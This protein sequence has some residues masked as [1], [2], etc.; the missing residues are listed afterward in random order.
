MN[1][2]VIQLGPEQHP[3]IQN[4]QIININ[5]NRNNNQKFL[6]I[7][8]FIYFFTIFSQ[9]LI[10]GIIFII[11]KHKN[12]N[13]A[14]LVLYCILNNFLKILFN[15][16][17]YIKFGNKLPDYK[18]VYTLEIILYT[19]YSIAYLGYYLN[20]VNYISNKNIFYFSLPL[21]PMNFFRASYGFYV[22]CKFLPAPTLYCLDSVF[23]LILGFRFGNIGLFGW[24]I[25][26]LFWYVI[27]GFLFLFC[28]IFLLFLLYY[29][30]CKTVRNRNRN[31]QNNR[32]YVVCFLFCL[33]LFCFYFS[34]CF[35][36]LVHGLRLYFDKGD[37]N[38]LYVNGYFMTFGALIII[39]GFSYIFYKLF[40]VINRELRKNTTE[41]INLVKF[42][43]KIQLEMQPVS[44]NYFKKKEEKAF[45]SQQNIIKLEECTICYER[46]GEILIKPCGHSGMCK[47][48]I[49]K[50][51]ENKIIC[52][53]CRKEIKEILI[54]E[55]D[56]E[57]KEYM[58][59]GNINFKKE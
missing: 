28:F 32:L 7:Y 51:L 35:F 15:I 12:S 43:K 56:E 25:A 19:G 4:Q 59:N 40:T 22:K 44:G 30:F 18:S 17:F 39:L 23:F 34:I 5:Q 10:S 9:F 50:C 21:L 46:K 41:K 37:Y 31:L 3:I 47:E 45:F 52:P 27:S 8:F 1:N 42:A 13:L 55:Y 29:F 57:K 58:A 11:I 53:T 49:L 38:L 26:F 2:P 14:Y 20:F 16:Y 24:I 36:N 48:C 6:G 54:L 33:L